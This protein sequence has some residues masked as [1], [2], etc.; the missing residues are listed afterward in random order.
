MKK[1]IL[2]LFVLLLS[3]LWLSGAQTEQP[4]KVKVTAEQANLRERPDIG[5]AIVQ[6]LPEGTVLDADKKEGEWFLVR[7]TLEDGGVIAGF[8]HESLVVVVD[9]KTAV[10]RPEE[11]INIQD[12]I[13]PQEKPART[14]ERR[15]PLSTERGLFADVPSYR[16]SLTAGW[17]WLVV[18][19][20]NS[21]AK[22]Y[23]AYTSAL[24]DI[25]PDG[26]I[27][28]LHQAYLGGI[29]F[30]FPLT[31]WLFLGIGVESFSGRKE[32]Y[33]TFQQEG[34]FDYII[35]RPS[36]RATPVKLSLTSYPQEW[37][38]IRGSLDIYFVKA[39]YFYQFDQ[40]LLREE[41]TGKATSMGLG[42]EGTLGREWEIGSVLSLFAEAGFRH[43]KIKGLKGKD[44]YANGGDDP[45]VEEG[46]LYYFTKT[47]ADGKNEPLLFVRE[48]RPDEEGV[49][50][51]RN[52][53]I[54]FTGA[55][56]KAGL[57]IR[58]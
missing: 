43:A 39:E 46:I 55:V 48:S 44:T 50:S 18:G 34:S 5:S 56:L 29:D 52:A 36:F 33:V 13:Q 58:F 30:S 19:D 31:S 21:G 10:R 40:T 24:L 23:G 53:M 47:S 14:P 11:A 16:I 2:L 57:R 42:F 25:P 45:V 32:S 37:W 4:L 26:S 28:T 35:T 51:V 6:Q 9:P 15:E 12:P 20:L 22:G 27:N 3:S 41:W 38:Y 17:N 54:D 1:R 7:Y 8:I 49:V